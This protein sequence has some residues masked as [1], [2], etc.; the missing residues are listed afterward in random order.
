MISNNNGFN[1]FSTGP[2]QLISTS[3]N[4]QAINRLSDDVKELF[5]SEVFLFPSAGAGTS[6]GTGGDVLVDLDGVDPKTTRMTLPGDQYDN[7]GNLTTAG[8]FRD[9][10]GRELVN[11]DTGA[12]RQALT[13]P[14][15]G[16]LRT[17]A[18][19]FLTTQSTG[20]SS[21]IVGGKAYAVGNLP[22]QLPGSASL[23]GSQSAL[24]LSYSLAGLLNVQ[25]VIHALEQ[26]TGSD[27][28]TAPRVTVL[29]GKT[30]TINVSQEFRY[31]TSYGDMESQVGGG[32]SDSSADT[33]S[34]SITPGTPQDFETANLGV[35]MEV[36]PTVED[37]STITLRLNP[38]VTEFEGFVEYGGSALAVSG[39]TV[40]QIP[41]G[42]YQPV[43]SVREVSTEVTIYDG[44]TVVLGGLTREEVKSF[45]DSIPFLGDLPLVGRLFRSEG[46]TRQKRNLLIFVNANLV[47]AGGSPSNQSAPGVKPNSL[48]QNPVIITPGG[49]VS[50]SASI[51]KE[52]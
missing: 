18:N 27:L 13:N 52:K 11:P 32:S 12:T 50:R 44:A 48:F 29:S 25:T 15:S 5:T 42:F 3:T 37:D 39:S 38:R 2:T 45:H 16:A 26:Q 14:G 19:S 28:M 21:V 41:S 9:M 35:M 7:L 40:V 46:E 33:A 4:G 36:T 23:G 43:F 20:A 8:P 47:S 17:L 34:V 10:V 22:P 30:A 24:D 51:S 1:L 6:G 31:P 49:A